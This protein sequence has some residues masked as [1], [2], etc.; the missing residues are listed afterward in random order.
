MTEILKGAI[1]NIHHTRKGFFQGVA[2]RDFDT[3][4][5]TFWPVN[6]ADGYVKGMSYGVDWWPGESIPCRG[7]LVRSYEV[8]K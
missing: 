7:S 3:E 2:T 1:L 4:K 6:L 5:E 8:V